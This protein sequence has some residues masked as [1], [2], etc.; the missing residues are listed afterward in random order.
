MCKTI[1]NGFTRKTLVEVSRIFSKSCCHCSMPA[2]LG[3]PTRSFRALC[4]S[5]YTQSLDN[6]SN[7][8]SNLLI[9][10][11]ARRKPA[12]GCAIWY[13]QLQNSCPRRAEILDF[14]FFPPAGLL[15]N[16]VNNSTTSQRSKSTKFDTNVVNSVYNNCHLSNLV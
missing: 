1:V 7:E 5:L 14:F 9:G 4:K 15:Q 11:L 16:R 8:E 2:S 10:T 3:A 12:A 6:Q 13:S